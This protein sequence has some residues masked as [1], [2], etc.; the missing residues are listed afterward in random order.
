V[1]DETAAPVAAPEAPPPAP[2]EAPANVCPIT[3]DF[4]PPNMKKHV[5]PKAPVPLRMMCAKALVPLAPPDMVGALF[6]LT[7]DADEKV[8]TTA[9][10][11][12]AKLPDRVLAP[13]LRDEGLQE[14][15]LAWLLDQYWQNDSYAEMLTLNSK[16]PDAAVA[17]AASKCSVRTAEIIAGNQLRILRDESIIK[18]LVTNP[19]VP[20][21]VID[22]VCDFAVRSG[23]IVD[24]PQMKDARV[25]LFGPEAAEK[26]PDPGPTADQ[27]LNEFDSALTEDA[28]PM[29]EGKRIT[30]SKQIMKM[31]V[32]EKVKL[33]TKGNKEAR[34][35][36]LR[37]SNRLVC[38]AAIR[39]PRI[40]D[41][42]VM[43]QAANK[44]VNED[45][46]RVIYGDREYIKQYP[47][48]LALVKNPKTPQALSM[49][50]L[51][52]LR[53]SDVKSLSRDKNVPNVVQQLARK[54]M[55]KK[56]NPHKK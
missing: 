43:A 44:A 3:A 13:A 4:L 21:S 15:V 17:R 55:E 36:L 56:E 10:E 28:P 34:G 24:L 42:E 19:A 52:T 8:R 47:I 45:V 37:D 38:V 32:S 39:N 6:M 40:T 23:M 1:S 27:V 48:K 46:L 7:F 49:R 54:M 12:A 30:F 26:P 9:I 16:T 53:E 2:A 31:S 41:G 18:A 5:D 35:I 50:F 51:S 20:A 14:A 22:S 11:T 29:E 33:A 25:R